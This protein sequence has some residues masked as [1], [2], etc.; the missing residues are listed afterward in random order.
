MLH[1]QPQRAIFEVEWLSFW[2]VRKGRCPKLTHVTLVLQSS[3]TFVCMHACMCVC[4]YVWVYACMHAC[5]YI[6]MGVC[7]YACMHAR[8]LIAMRDLG[9]TAVLQ[10][11]VTLPLYY[12]AQ[13]RYRC[14]TQSSVT[15]PLYYKAQSR[16]P[17]HTGMY[18]LNVCVRQAD[19][20]YRTCL[21]KAR[22]LGCTEARKLKCSSAP[23]PAS[24]SRRPTNLL[25]RPAA[26]LCWYVGR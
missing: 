3:D 7:V 4:M 22:S 19:I 2:G 1:V 8:D 10:S 15:L 23:P 13:S 26:F 5:M 12:K 17:R 6:C 9:P 20:H 18:S 14:T 25:L 11:T 24:S 16:Y 21:R